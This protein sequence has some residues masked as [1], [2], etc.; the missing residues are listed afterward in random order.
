M[1]LLMAF[2]VTALGAVYFSWVYVECNYNLWVAIG[3]HMFMNFCWI[4]F[5]AEGNVNAAGTLLPN[6]LRLASIALTIILIVFYK[7][8]Q[9]SKIFRYPIFSI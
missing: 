9:S 8:K 5:P 2:S 4:V 3:L 7:K 1:S 6:I